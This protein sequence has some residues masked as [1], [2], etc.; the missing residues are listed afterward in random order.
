[1]HSTEDSQPPQAENR[2]ST[3]PFRVITPATDPR[4]ERLWEPVDDAKGPRQKR[5]LYHP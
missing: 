4:N 3:G 1:M 5:P 2:E